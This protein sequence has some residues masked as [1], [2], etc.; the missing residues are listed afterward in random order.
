MTFF[1]TLAGLFFIRNVLVILDGSNLLRSKLIIPRLGPLG[2]LT[3]VGCFFS[4]YFSSSSHSNRYIVNRE[5]KKELDTFVIHTA[6]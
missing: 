4:F 1:F 2:C 3:S 6:R 5:R